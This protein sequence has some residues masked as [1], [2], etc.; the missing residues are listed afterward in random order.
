VRPHVIAQRVPGLV[1]ASVAIAHF[2]M[3]LRASLVC[4]DKL[5]FAEGIVVVCSS[6]LKIWRGSRWCR[7][8][9][10][11]PRPPELEDVQVASHMKKQVK[12]EIWRPDTSSGVA[13]KYS[14]RVDKI[15]KDD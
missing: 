11:V 12:Q 8:G 9:L 3:V 2:F 1:Q 6:S 4:V 14:E 7:C 5:M 10:S 15:L 13:S